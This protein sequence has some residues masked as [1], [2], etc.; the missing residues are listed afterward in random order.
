MSIDRKS[1]KQTLSQLCAKPLT[2]EGATT[3]P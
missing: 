3:I 1:K 2:E